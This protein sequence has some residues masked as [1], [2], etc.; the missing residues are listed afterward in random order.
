ME[1][2]KEKLNKINPS[3]WKFDLRSEGGEKGDSKL[4]RP[5]V[6]TSCYISLEPPADLLLKSSDNKNH[7]HDSSKV[8]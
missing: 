6:H 8:I 7:G 1:H 3:I 2:I 5:D 4:L